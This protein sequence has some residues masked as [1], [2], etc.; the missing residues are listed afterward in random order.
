M[1][2]LEWLTSEAGQEFVKTSKLTRWLFDK[3][4]EQI[5]DYLKSEFS[6]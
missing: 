2:M 6:D 4:P 3:A 5:S 1:I